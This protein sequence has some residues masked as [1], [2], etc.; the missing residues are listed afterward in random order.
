VNVTGTASLGATFGTTTL[1]WYTPT[2]LGANPEY[3]S[4][5]GVDPKKICNG[6]AVASWLL[7]E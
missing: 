6:G 2:R 1:S 7:P 3:W 5:A 4:V